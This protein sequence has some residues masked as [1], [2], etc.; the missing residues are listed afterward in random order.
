MLF[1]KRKLLLAALVAVFLWPLP[2]EAA[3]VCEDRK[4]TLEALQRQYGEV[5]VAQGV[6]ANGD[7]V[8]VVAT[9][10][11]QTWTIIVTRPGGKSCIVGFGKDWVMSTA[12]GREK[13]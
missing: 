2:G 1:V 5:P 8:E 12:S 7:L 4:G 11:G 9:A 3:P 10:T 13:T 6:D